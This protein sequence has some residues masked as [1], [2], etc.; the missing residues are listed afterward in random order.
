MYNITT[1]IIFPFDGVTNEAK[2][3]SRSER[4]IQSRPL[5]SLL[6]RFGTP[7]KRFTCVSRCPASLTRL[8][9]SR[10]TRRMRVASVRILKS[11]RTGLPAVSRY[12]RSLWRVRCSEAKDLDTSLAINIKVLIKWKISAAISNR[13]FNYIF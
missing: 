3:F 7:R 13:L 4:G 9:R 11:L 10:G 5:K 2:E 12:Q 6:K 1:L 8:L